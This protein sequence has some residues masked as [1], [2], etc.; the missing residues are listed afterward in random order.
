MEDFIN[1]LYSLYDQN[2]PRLCKQSIAK[3][4]D[5]ILGVLFPEVAES[6]V[7]TIEDYSVY[8]NQN[9]N[10]LT[11]IFNC[12]RAD[13]HQEFDSEKVIEDFY[14]QLPKLAQ[15]LKE[16]AKFIATQ[17]PAAHSIEEVILCYPGMYAIGLYRISNLL[18]SMGVRL[19]PR[20]LCE[21]AHS[22]T[23]IDIHPAATID[24]PFFIDHGTGIVIGETTKIG[25]RVKIFQ[26]VT[27]GA[28]SVSREMKETQRHPIIEDDCL[29]YSN[30]T[31]LGGKT[32][33]GK[34]STIGGN[35]WITKSVPANSM[36]SFEAK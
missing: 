11:Q 33:I 34:G 19:L 29:I 14:N 22:K 24:S 1:K 20:V 23:G 17:D 2:N 4:A 10:Y 18:Y 5:S 27:L 13:F 25:K 8:V 9:K 6:P 28:L 31:I 21:H 26:G 16:D 3:F 15:T 32:V 36:I 30:A 35:V 7:H 12:L